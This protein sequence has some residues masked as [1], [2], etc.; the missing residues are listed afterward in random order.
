MPN[1]LYT[2]VNMPGFIYI[3]D[4][5]V[6][7][8]SELFNTKVAID[9]LSIK[10]V[11]KESVLGMS[12]GLS[13]HYAEKMNKFSMQDEDKCAIFRSFLARDEALTMIKKK[14]DVAKAAAKA[15]AEAEAAAAAAAAQR[16]A[17]EAAAA[18]SAAASKLKASVTSA[19]SAMTPSTKK[20]DSALSSVK[21][22]MK[23]MAASASAVTSSKPK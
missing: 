15:K 18:A 9:Y 12:T 19:A 17:S 6:C 21:S 10:Y 20:L 23:S 3:A 1:Y 7:F 2:Y 5:K 4:N 22:S 13:I 14:I 16:A 11:C 8:H